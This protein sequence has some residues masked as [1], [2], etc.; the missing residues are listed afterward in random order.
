MVHTWGEV[1]FDPVLL[2]E[3]VE[4]RVSTVLVSYLRTFG[5]LCKSARVDATVPV[6]SARWEGLVDGVF[7]TVRRDGMAD[8]RIRLS[9]NLIGAPALTGSVFVFTVNDEFWNGNK[10]EQDGLWALQYHVVRTFPHRLWAS[11]SGAWGWGGKSQVNDV[12]KD[13]LKKN[14]LF[15]VAFGFPAGAK[16]SGKLVYW[17]AD[18]QTHVGI[19]AHNVAL[20][21]SVL[22]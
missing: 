14:A 17:R 19:E 16:S 20:A 12:P 15:S 8:P 1:L 22:F 6:Q 18:T 21:W 10:R 5:V 9:V 4:M 3:N 7:T 11:L 2:V 13:D